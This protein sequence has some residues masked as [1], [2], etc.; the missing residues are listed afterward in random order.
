MCAFSAASSVWSWEIRS[1]TSTPAAAT[2]GG[3]GSGRGCSRTLRSRPSVRIENSDGPEMKLPPG[4]SVF[5]RSTACPSA[6]RP[7]GAPAGARRGAESFAAPFGGGRDLAKGAAPRGAP[8]APRWVAPTRARGGLG[9]L[10]RSLARRVQQL[11]GR[12]QGAAG[13]G[14]S[15]LPATCAANCRPASSS[16]VDAGGLVSVSRS[17]SQLHPGWPGTRP[18]RRSSSAL[19][20][21]ARASL[22]ARALACSRRCNTS[23]RKASTSCAPF[24]SRSATNT[25]TPSLEAWANLVHCRTRVV[26]R[27]SG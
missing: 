6:R 14:G 26:R 8:A 13:L 20:Q 19:P 21:P 18:G 25:G 1:T 9:H 7:P 17:G 12:G 16:A 27:Y 10:R 4:I 23:F 2:L 5:C 22:S 24:E 11:A 15:G 3:S